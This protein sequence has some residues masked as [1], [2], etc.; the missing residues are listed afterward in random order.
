MTRRFRRR[1]VGVGVLCCVLVLTLSLCS[2]EVIN[3]DASSSFLTKLTIGVVQAVHWMKG[4]FIGEAKQDLPPRKVRVAAVGLGRTGSTSM[5][6][7]LRRLG[8]MPIHDDQV[9]EVSDI[10]DGMMNDLTMD[11]VNQQFGDRG[12][13]APMISSYEY[14]A[15][16]ATQPDVKVILT[17]R[18]PKKWAQSWLKITPVAYIPTRP[19]FSW[20]KTMQEVQAYNSAY[21]YDLVTQGHPELFEDV[22]TLEKGFEAYNEFVK[23]TVPPER[24]LVFSVKEGWEPL[25]NFLDQPVP[26]EPFPHIND[27]VVITVIIRTMIIVTWI[28]PLILLVPLACIYCCCCCRQNQKKKKES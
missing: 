12:F 8:Y 5:S 18:D 6:A 17:V 26:D 9:T 25:C 15:W 10:L 19:P 27:K 20:I 4:F 21:F 23:A 1:V 11:E 2:A 16:A 24:L 22:P 13:D 7:A 3:T 28:W 14:V